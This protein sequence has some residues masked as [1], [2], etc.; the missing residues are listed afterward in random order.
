MDP[1]DRVRAL[2]VAWSEARRNA[3]PAKSWIVLAEKVVALHHELDTSHRSADRRVTSLGLA[4]ARRECETLVVEMGKVLPGMLE[5]EAVSTDNGWD[6]DG[7]AEAKASIAIKLDPLDVARI[8]VR[9]DVDGDEVFRSLAAL[10]RLLDS[11][12]GL[13]LID[14]R[15]MQKYGRECGNV[16][17]SWLVARESRRPRRVAVIT[18]GG[19]PFVRATDALTKLAGIDWSIGVDEAPALRWLLSEPQQ[20]AR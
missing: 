14:A 20:D 18:Q 19:L 9:G 11:S 12:D 16:I 15:A 1:L 7:A 3:A 17:Q 6:R 10:D 4:R 13:V 8:T 5:A 2:A